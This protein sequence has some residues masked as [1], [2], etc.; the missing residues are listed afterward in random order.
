[1]NPVKVNLENHVP[2]D[3]WDGIIA[4]G[5]VK[6]GIHDMDAAAVMARMNFTKVGKRQPSIYFSTE[7]RPADEEGNPIG[8]VLFPINIVDGPKWEFEIPPVHY[9]DWSPEPGSYEGHFEVTDANDKRWTIY[10]IWF[11]VL[12]DK[13]K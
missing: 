1:M 13:T 6:N 5:P 4:I 12:D 2:G 3:T 8:P 9:N 7:P 11:E 10:H